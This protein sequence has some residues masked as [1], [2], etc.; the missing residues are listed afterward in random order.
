M[1]FDQAYIDEQALPS[2]LQKDP[3][4]GLD[5]I[6]SIM[7]FLG[8]TAQQMVE[9]ILGAAKALQH[10]T[11]RAGGKIARLY[12]KKPGGGPWKDSIDIFAAAGTTKAAARAALAPDLRFLS[13]WP[14]LRLYEE[15]INLRALSWLSAA[16]GGA[17]AWIQV[18]HK[19][20]A[21][22]ISFQ[23]LSR[24][25]I[26]E[27]IPL[28][29]LDATASEDELCAL[30]QRRFDLLDLQVDWEGLRIWIRQGMGKGKT[31]GLDDGQIRKYLKFAVAQ[32]PA[33]CSLALLVTHKGIEDRA[34]KIVQELRP[35][36][37]WESTHY[38]A[39]RGLNTFEAC[40]AVLCFGVPTLNPENTADLACYLFPDDPVRQGEW[41]QYQ[42]EAEL[43]QCVHRARF[44]RNRGRTLIVMGQYWP[45]HLLGKPDQTFDGRKGRTS[46]GTL[47]R[48][49]LAVDRVLPL[50]DLLGFFTK[51]TAAWIGIGYRDDQEKIRQTRWA[52]HEMRLRLEGKESIEV[53]Q[54]PLSIL[55]QADTPE[56]DNLFVFGR[57]NFWT[58]LLEELE[59]RRPGTGRLPVKLPTWGNRNWTYAVGS[60]AAA[61]AW[62]NNLA[63]C[64]RELGF[65]SRDFIEDSWREGWP[66]KDGQTR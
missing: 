12:S 64:L 66:G 54:H 32:L 50:L 15:G 27:T 7:P 56:Y 11:V 20:K 49:K 19:N 4:I 37:L 28:T 24:A 40:S 61:R 51:E 8:E 63:M 38:F 22:P 17:V 5:E 29:V 55:R 18:N 41:I 60:T 26:P 31:Q 34:L 59:L 9:Q 65:E 53:Y 57:R 13:D 43:Y 33:N 47:E 35:G 46:D 21:R 3:P 6:Q 62:V 36:V 58:E 44:V 23:L 39:S 2:L 48:M 30:F 14:Q 42:S 10:A 45:E 52:L 25:R 16:A 1:K